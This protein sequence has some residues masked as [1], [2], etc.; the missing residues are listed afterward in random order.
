VIVGGTGLNFL[1]LTEGLAEVPPTPREVRTEGD[2][3]SLAALVAGLDPGTAAGIDLRNR[4]RVQR[5]WEVLRA[6]GRGLAGWQADT[7]PPALPLSA[8]TALVLRPDVAWLDDRIARR[9][10]MMLD[11]G[12]LEEARAMLPRWNPAHLSSKAIG[13]AELIAHLRGEMTLEEARDRAVLAT[14][15]YAK[16]QRTWLRNRM[17]EWITV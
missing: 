10:D 4:A 3:L 1:A 5:A 13:A 15:R 7:P 16:R 9:F 17:A 6:T 8:A 11:Q 14:R 12:V 2:A